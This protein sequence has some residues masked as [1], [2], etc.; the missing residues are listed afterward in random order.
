MKKISGF[1]FIIFI[2]L[3]LIACGGS[4]DCV[5][6]DW[7]GTWSGTI[8]DQ[9][10]VPTDAQLI[11]RA[12]GTDR[13]D[14]SL[15]GIDFDPIDFSGCNFSLSQSQ[16]S[17]LGAIAIDVDADLDGDAINFDGTFTVFGITQPYAIL[18]TRQ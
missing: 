6:E 12:N 13:L 16:D 18:L 4:G 5:Q 2:S 11:I 14:I 3:F 1:A 10:G 17:F 9:D 7:V 15:D 8:V